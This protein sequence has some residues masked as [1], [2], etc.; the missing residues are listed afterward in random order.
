MTD[1]ITIEHNDDRISVI[2][3]S[4]IKS[5][6][7]NRGDTKVKMTDNNTIWNTVLSVKDVYDRILKAGE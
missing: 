1:F 5:V 6:S 3:V 4:N 2:R 7:T